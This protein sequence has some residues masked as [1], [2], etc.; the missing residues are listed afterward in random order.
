[1]KYLKLYENFGNDKTIKGFH[2]SKTPISK[3][4]DRFLVDDYLR[5][6]PEGFWFTYE[7]DEWKEFYYNNKTDSYFMYEIVIDSTNIITLDSIDKINNFNE[8]YESDKNIYKHKQDLN[9][10]VY[11]MIW[12][13]PNWF[14]VKKDY[15]GIEFP[16]Y[17]ELKNEIDFN[18]VKN[19]W[20]TF[21]DVN[22]GCIWN[23]KAVVN[24]KL[25]DK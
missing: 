19:H 7:S 23:K 21:I 6:K 17:E 5:D 1:M 15:Y 16:N 12:T 22:S 13:S 18:D 11:S 2:I 24:F 25:L 14:K 3:I 20:L 10:T 8:K 9:E 4:D